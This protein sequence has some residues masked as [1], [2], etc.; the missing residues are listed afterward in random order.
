MI[1][2]YFCYQVETC[3]DHFHN[4]GNCIFILKAEDAVEEEVDLEKLL[5]SRKP[6]E[7]KDPKKTLRG[8]FEREGRWR[9]LYCFI[10]RG[11]LHI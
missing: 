11:L 1:L 7:L 10:F 4:H 6:L 9:K 8:F 3:H 5:A 2:K